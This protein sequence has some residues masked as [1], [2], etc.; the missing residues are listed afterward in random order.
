VGRLLVIMTTILRGE[1]VKQIK[2]GD[3][4]LNLI[5]AKALVFFVR[6]TPALKGGVN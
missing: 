5:R 2:R 3:L 1:S 4:I 6:L